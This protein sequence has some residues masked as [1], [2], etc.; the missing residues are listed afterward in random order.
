MATILFTGVT[1][2]VGSSL[3]PLLKSKGDRLI[4]L[5]RSK[6]EQDPKDRL[7]KIL[8]RIN[9]NEIVW[10][11]D[12]TLPHAGVSDSE[13][14]RWKGQIDKIVHYKQLQSQVEN[15]QI[16]IF[17]QIGTSVT[18][19]GRLEKVEILSWSK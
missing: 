19:G 1:G 9:D 14:R 13:R 12:V 6:S 3:A 8:G 16:I 2:A 10:K 5:V 4:Y 11:G 18:I 17:L 15:G 7:S